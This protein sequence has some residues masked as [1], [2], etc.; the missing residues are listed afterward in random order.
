[1]SVKRDGVFKKVELVG[2]NEFIK[3]PL[4]EPAWLVEPLFEMDSL[5]ILFGASG[6]GKSFVAL[7]W[8]M[9]IATGTPWLGKYPVAQ[10]P[11]LY[12]IAEGQRGMTRRAA[13]ARRHLGVEV[14]SGDFQF[15]PG[16]PQLRNEK[17]LEEFLKLVKKMQAKFVIIDTLARTMIGGDENTAKDMGE[18]VN[19]AAIIQ[20]ETGACVMP[21]HHTAK[22]KKPGS[23]PSE[24]GSGALRGAVDTSIGVSMAD[25]VITLTNFKQKE[26]CLFSPIMVGTHVYELRPRTEEKKAMTSLVLVPVEETIPLELVDAT[27]L[28]VEL[29]RKAATQLTKTE[30]YGLLSREQKRKGY[31]VT[32]KATFFRWPDRLV[33]EGLV[34]KEGDLYSVMTLVKPSDGD[35]TAIAV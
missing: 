18:W 26:D 5:T 15:Y 3:E 7:S 9:A 35:A 25:G 20:Q 2:F 4:A 29:L 30:W 21:V 31:P 10:A 23:P 14:A 8:A 34:R 13:A 17:G 19:A 27:S 6:E 32:P 16:A 24:R 22:H 12:A 1:V 11:V 33:E 28:A